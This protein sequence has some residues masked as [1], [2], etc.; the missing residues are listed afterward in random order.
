MV[1]LDKSFHFSGS[2]TYSFFKNSS[3]EWCFLWWLTCPVID[4]N[5]MW[6][7]KVQIKSS[8]SSMKEME[9]NLDISKRK[10]FNAEN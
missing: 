1:A 4:L 6:M 5:N 10:G 9:T 7:K 2:Q 3:D 8:Q